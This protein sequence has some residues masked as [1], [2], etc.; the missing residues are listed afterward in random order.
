MKTARAGALH[1]RPGEPE[2]NMGQCRDEN[3]V[4]ILHKRNG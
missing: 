1:T 4:L 3:V 2:I